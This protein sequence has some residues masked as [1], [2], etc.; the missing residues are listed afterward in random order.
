MKELVGDAR[1]VLV[2]GAGGGYDVLGAVPLLHD[3]EADGREVHLASL[4]FTY[5]NGL[6]RARQI[7][8]VGCL[9]EVGGDAA[10]PR[11][12]CP[13]AWLA[14]HLGRPIWCF[15]KV[16]V[17]LLANAYRW[18]ARELA[19]DCVVLVDGGIDLILRGDETS[20]GTPA[21]DLASLAAVAQLELPARA[22][23]LGLGSELRDGIAHEQAFA[24][25]AELTRD[26]GYLGAHA[27]VG[28]T[29]RGRRYRAAME[30]VTGNQAG[31]KHSHVHKVV[32]AAM[33]GDYGAVAPHVWL[34]AL[35][36]MHWWFDLHAV[37]RGHRFLADLRDTE[38]IWDVAARIEAA[39]KTLAIRGR[40][41]IPI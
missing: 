26:G 31:L 41:S 36:P 1:R 16:G 29:E 22:A 35:L 40:T 30:F 28:A 27:L 8:E 20:L 34:S 12:Y 38:S 25:I 3:L 32:L 14:R 19:I 33:T 6:D 24:R 13:E 15:D 39:R 10:V 18:L 23:C 21:E 9:Y 4:S 5:L 2:A 7:A 37:A 17:G 11:A